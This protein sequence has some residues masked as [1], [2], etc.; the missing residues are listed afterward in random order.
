[1]EKKSHGGSLSFLWQN[2]AGHRALFVA[3]MAGTVVYNA[4]QLTVPV[5]TGQLVDLFLTG[6]E[7]AANLATRREL[8]WTLIGTMIGLTLLRVIIVYLDCMSYEKC[9]QHALYRIRTTLYDKVQR[10]DMT[11]YAKYRTGDLMTRMTGDLDAVRHMIAWVVRML[12]ECFSL[13]TAAAVYFLIINW[14]LALALL[15]LTPVICL[16]VYRFRVRVKPMHELL[17]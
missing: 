9:S 5:F 4:L 17:R 3:G 16:L 7:A 6:S 13:F 12:L 2:M 15:A 11:F 1:M 8:F 10:Q 14:R